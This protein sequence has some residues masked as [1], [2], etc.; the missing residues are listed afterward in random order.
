MLL[1]ALAAVRWAVAALPLL[2]CAASAAASCWTAAALALLVPIFEIGAVLVVCRGGMAGLA[3]AGR[4][5]TKRRP[6]AAA[7]SN[8]GRVL[9]RALL[10]APG[11]GRVEPAPGLRALRRDGTTAPR[12]RGSSTEATRFG[13]EIGGFSV[14][15]DWI[16]APRRESPET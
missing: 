15:D 2:C 6:S 11:R 12:R 9:G 4:R 10:L 5:G 16:P 7:D 8:R 3:V 13:Y 14:F 1:A